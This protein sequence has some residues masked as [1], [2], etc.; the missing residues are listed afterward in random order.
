MYLNF[1]AKNQHYILHVNSF[2][3]DKDKVEIQIFGRFAKNH[4]T[5]R[6]LTFLSFKTLPSTLFKT[7]LNS[8]HSVVQ[9][10]MF[11]SPEWNSVVAKVPRH[12]PY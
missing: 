3:C 7:Y 8:E 5:Q 6:Q 11:F 12:L 1:R 10:V 2:L 9:K 4:P